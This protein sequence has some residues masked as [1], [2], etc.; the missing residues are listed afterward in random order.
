M[1]ETTWLMFG[2]GMMIDSYIEYLDALFG[3]I[4]SEDI[5]GL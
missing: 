2:I 4:E 1:S 3:R 5:Y